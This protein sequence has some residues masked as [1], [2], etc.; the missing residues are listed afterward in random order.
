MWSL[1]CLCISPFPDLKMTNMIINTFELG[2]PNCPACPTQTS[3]L[4]GRLS[5]EDENLNIATELASLDL[6]PL[7]THVADRKSDAA[8]RQ[9][10]LRGQTPSNNTCDERLCP[11]PLP[12]IPPPSAPSAGISLN[13][14]TYLLRH[15]PHVDVCGELFEIYAQSCGGFDGSSSVVVTTCQNQS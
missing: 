14:N 7:T 10:K 1:F 6:L 5:G 8:T 3:G 11:W 9:R 12:W 15:M 4:N 13:L 2:C